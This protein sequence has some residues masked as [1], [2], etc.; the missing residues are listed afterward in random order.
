MKQVNQKA[1]SVKVDIEIY[2]EMELFCKVIGMKRNRVINLALKEYM[3][4]QKF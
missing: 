4:N 3:A 2:A 1:I